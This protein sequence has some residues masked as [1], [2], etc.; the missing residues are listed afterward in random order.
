MVCSISGPKSARTLLSILV[1]RCSK[2]SPNNTQELFRILQE[3][4]Y[5]LPN[6]LSMNLLD[7]IPRRCQ[8]VIDVNREMT[9]Y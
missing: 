6:E 3:E 8:A 7:S 1:S 4:W 9:K 5:K 2:G